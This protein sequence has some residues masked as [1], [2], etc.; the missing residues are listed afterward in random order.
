MFKSPII[1]LEKYILNKVCWENNHNF[2]IN[3]Y[4]CTIFLSFAKN[5]TPQT[6]DILL[7]VLK[8]RKELHQIVYTSSNIRWLSA[9]KYQPFKTLNLL[10]LKA[11]ETTGTDKLTCNKRTKFSPKTSTTALR[12]I[13]YVCHN[14]HSCG[15]RWRHL[16]SFR[17]EE[18]VE[19]TLIPTSAADRL[20]FFAG[21][22]GLNCPDMIM[23]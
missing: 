16:N 3:T 19:Y 21:G 20:A 1:L 9:Q 5:D 23:G 2:E 6:F 12:N 8:I 22:S 14:S 4:V 10:Y 15:F 7:D 13:V 11:D 17:T 18:G